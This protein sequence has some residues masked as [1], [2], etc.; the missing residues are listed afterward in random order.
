MLNVVT[1]LLVEWQVLKKYCIVFSNIIN[2]YNKKFV[3]K[4]PC[5]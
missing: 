1:S 5:N 4:N 2:T 3:I